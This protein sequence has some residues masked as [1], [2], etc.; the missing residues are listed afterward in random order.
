LSGSNSYSKAKTASVFGWVNSE[1][2][3][4]I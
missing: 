4:P 2:V 1:I 3:K